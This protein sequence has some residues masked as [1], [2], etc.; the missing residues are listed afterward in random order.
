[1]EGSIAL[2]R[3]HGVTLDRRIMSQPAVLTFE[4]IASSRDLVFYTDLHRLQPL[5]NDFAVQYDIPTSFELD[6]DEP[7]DHFQV[8]S[9][10]PLTLSEF[11]SDDTEPAQLGSPSSSMIVTFTKPHRNR[12]PQTLEPE[13]DSH[14]VAPG[15]RHEPADAS[16]FCTLFSPLITSEND[17][18]LLETPASEDLPLSSFSP[19]C[20]SSPSTPSQH[21]PE[22]DSGTSPFHIS[23]SMDPGVMDLEPLGR[24]R[25]VLDDTMMDEDGHL[26]WLAKCFICELS[27][28]L[29]RAIF[30]EACHED[31]LTS[32][33]MSALSIGLVCRLW[34]DVILSMKQAWASFSLIMKAGDNPFC[35]QLVPLLELYL[36]RSGN[37]PISFKLLCESRESELLL[38]R[39]IEHSAR[40]EN[41]SITLPSK[42]LD[43]LCHCDFPLL[44]TL[45]FA[46]PNHEG[47]GIP[48]EV[49]FYMGRTPM[50]HTLTICSTL[51]RWPVNVKTSRII[52]FATNSIPLSLAANYLVRLP[53]VHTFT[54]N[55]ANIFS[56]SVPLSYS[57]PTL[58]SVRF[59]CGTYRINRNALQTFL[60][61]LTLPSATSIVIDLPGWKTVR[62]E[63]WS[64]TAMLWSH[65]D[66][67]SFI[68]RSACSLQELNL[69][70]VNFTVMELGICLEAIPT[71]RILELDEPPA[72][73]SSVL[74]TALTRSSSP[75]QVILLPTLMRLK[76]R[77]CLLFCDDDF[78]KMVESR[79]TS[80]AILTC[81]DVTFR[82]RKMQTSSKSQLLALAAGGLE[83]LISEI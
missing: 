15:T 78:V 8:V 50:L 80:D 65:Q 49:E 32:R 28:E 19:S 75:C 74:V 66:F 54:Y 25:D 55:Y 3:C 68:K 61:C 41:V 39:L 17:D 40:W 67:L 24:R 83:V 51:T 10:L 13:R 11:A 52:N 57:H 14:E 70:N 6:N 23:Q 16:S 81:I 30:L 82:F 48:S 33:S 18:S 2:R 60:S 21:I 38:N 79:M 71:L 4:T 9:D 73:S 59:K 35:D 63:L 7:F 12:S 47:P 62:G 37:T 45:E 36:R 34:R 42:T 72:F 22:C 76:W 27:V 69:S 5:D 53:T 44:K 29:L 26:Y 20:P 43:G 46:C 56:A 1:V 31:C 77:G 58:R 64:Y